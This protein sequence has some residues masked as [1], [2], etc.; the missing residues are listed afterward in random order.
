VIFVLIC[1]Y[2]RLP[3]WYLLWQVLLFF[4]IP[5]IR[6]ELIRIIIDKVK[7]WLSERDT[8]VIRI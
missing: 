5:A 3:L 2:F 8:V 6:E 1:T 4:L 7:E